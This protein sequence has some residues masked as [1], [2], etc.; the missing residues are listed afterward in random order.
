[1]PIL[2]YYLVLVTTTVVG[3][4]RWLGGCTVVL[5]VYYRTTTVPLSSTTVL[6]LRLVTQGNTE[7][8]RLS[9]GALESGLDTCSLV[10]G[11]VKSKALC[12]KLDQRALLFTGCHCKVQSPLHR[13][14]GLC[15]LQPCSAGG[16]IMHMIHDRCPTVI[17]T[18]SW[19]VTVTLETL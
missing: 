11:C 6:V 4:V 12:I 8:H 1:M 16:T 19:P 2:P 9:H 14:T 17:P 5:L 15:T 18:A 10:Q 13:C 3:P 7:C